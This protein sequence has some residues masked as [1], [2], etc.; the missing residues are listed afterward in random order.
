M[1]TGQVLKNIEFKKVSGITSTKCVPK[2]SL[3]SGWNLSKFLGILVESGRR[4]TQGW[5]RFKYHQIWWHLVKLHVFHVSISLILVSY[6]IFILPILMRH[7]GE[8]DMEDVVHHY[9]NTLNKRVVLF[10]YFVKPK[11]FCVSITYLIL[12]WNF[13]GPKFYFDQPIIGFN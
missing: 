6:I 11:K 1:L 3:E 5:N 10:R 4:K 13:R 9:Y 2:N 8:V 12:G 7:G